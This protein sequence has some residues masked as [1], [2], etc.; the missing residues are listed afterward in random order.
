MARKKIKG[1]AKKGASEV[2]KKWSPLQKVSFRASQIMG[3]TIGAMK[4]LAKGWIRVAGLLN[5]TLEEKLY[6]ALHHADMKAYARERLNL[7]ERS[8]YN[9][10]SVYAWAKK[11]HPEWLDPKYKGPLPDFSD[12]GDLMW[13]EG[14][15]EQTGLTPERRAILED[16]KKMGLAGKLRRS[17]VRKVRGRKNTV[18]T[19]LKGA[20]SKLRLARKRIGEL[21][22]ISPEV[23]SHIDAAIQI[24]VNDSALKV[25]RL[26]DFG[27]EPEKWRQNYLA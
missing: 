21:A 10:L 12:V 3:Q 8:L 20:I 2:T 11:N 26:D 4:C 15:L 27:S 16:L 1:K 6:E 17:D 19:G 7:G 13:I 5:I 25:A 22:N 18:D 23:L 14:E 24:L 9:Y